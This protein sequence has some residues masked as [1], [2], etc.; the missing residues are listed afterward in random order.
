MPE[1]TERDPA[2]FGVDPLAKLDTSGDHV[3][4]PARVP[5][6]Q[7]RWLKLHGHRQQVTWWTT[8]LLVVGVS[9]LPTDGVSRPLGLVL[10]LAG[11]VGLG[12]RLAIWQVL[13]GY[14]HEP[15]V[16]MV[17][18]PELVMVADGD[19]PQSEGTRTIGWKDVVSVLTGVTDEAGERRALLLFQDRDP[20]TS[21]EPAGVR[22]PVVLDVVHVQD[23]HRLLPWVHRTHPDVVLL[24]A[25]GST[26]TDW[27]TMRPEWFGHEVV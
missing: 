21:E 4:V 25:S 11:L 16:R 26:L 14:L 9:M 22:L 19:P 10:T 7:L 20:R 6:A 23:I 13:R 24:S 8:I 17:L 15:R 18:S 12:L 2:L 27:R 3:F 5:F 1:T